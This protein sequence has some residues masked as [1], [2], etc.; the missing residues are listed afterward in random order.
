MCPA[1][2]TNRTRG[3]AR[4]VHGEASQPLLGAALGM[5]F[6]RVPYSWRICI[7]PAYRD[8]AFSCCIK[9][10][11]KAREAPGFPCLH[12]ASVGS[13]T[14]SQTQEATRGGGPWGRP[15]SLWVSGM[16]CLTLSLPCAFVSS[17]PLCPQADILRGEGPSPAG[18]QTGQDCQHIRS[19][20]VLQWGS[21]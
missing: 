10:L 15:S 16:S 4:R 8:I 12:R 14:F 6:R 9:E 13:W 3:P 1:K 21:R 20:L 19:R 11:L 18:P 7:R 5:A 2:K 17:Q